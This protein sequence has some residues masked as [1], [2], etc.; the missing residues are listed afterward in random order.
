MTAI[1]L[2][3]GVYVGYILRSG[4]KAADHPRSAGKGLC[5]MHCRRSAGRP[6]AAGG[7]LPGTVRRPGRMAVM[8]LVQI[9]AGVSWDAGQPGGPTMNFV[10]KRGGDK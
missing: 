6:V 4:N 5:P 10:R 9:V 2:A 8:K 7:S 1:Q 3:S